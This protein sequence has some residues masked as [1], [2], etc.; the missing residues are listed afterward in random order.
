MVKKMKSSPGRL[1]ASEIRNFLNKKA[2]RNV[3]FDLSK[4][5]PTE[6]KEWIPT[7]SRWLDGIICRGKLSGIPVGKIVEI[8]GLESTGKSYMAAQIAANAQ[9]MGMQVVYFDSE[10]AL[11]PSFLENIGCDV[12]ELVY[13]QALTVEFVLEQIEDIIGLGAEK[14]LFIWDSL[15]LTPAVSDVEGD[16]NPQSSMAVKAR[17]LAKG[18]SKLTVPI[19]NSN[20]T[21]LVLNQL[22]TN[23]T[24]N[25][26]EAMTTPFVTPGGKAMHYVYSLRLWLTGRKA[27]ASFITD[28][29]GYRIGSEVKCTLK[30][31]RFGTQ[32]RQCT[33]K[34]LW[35]GDVYIQD[36]ESWFE[37]IK[38]SKQIEQKGA[39]YSLLY[40]DGTSEKF[41]A[42]KWKEKLKDEKFRK[43]ALEIMD[44]EVVLRFEERS[45]DASDFYDIDGETEET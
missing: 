43:R 3:A 10:S 22:K 29:R 41:Q 5:N 25:I 14:T 45:G 4:D 34:I 19:A 37:A 1:S 18:M 21:L 9:K 6:V 13:Q 12:N 24:S 32:G 40:A 2:G 8:A 35:G 36:E 23:I 17:I 30:K 39:W 26:A 27:K 16:F 44:E 15:A 28:E 42:A 33:F 11:D 7:G 38:G 31:S 20:S